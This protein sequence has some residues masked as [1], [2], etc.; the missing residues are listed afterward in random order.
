MKVLA[1]YSTEEILGGG[2]ISFTLSLELV[3]KSGCDVLAALPGTGPLIDYLQKRG[4]PL[5][6]LPQPP[7]RENLNARYLFFPHPDWL[8]LCKGFRP[9]LIHC[10]AVRSALYAQ[11]VGNTLHIPAILHARKSERLRW[12]DPFLVLRL[13]AIICTSEIV[14]RRFPICLGPNKLK[15]VYN[16]VDFAQFERPTSQSR[17]LRE[18]WLNGRFG[19]LVGVIGRLSPIKGQHRIVEAAPEIL[20]SV[21]R[22]RFVL[23]GSED[24]SFPGHAQQLHNDIRRRGLEDH[25]VFAGYQTEIA[26]FYHALDVVAFPTSSEGFG[27]VVIEA[28]AARKAVVMSDIAVLREIVSTELEDLTVPLGDVLLLAKRIVLLLRDKAL[29]AEVGERLYHHVQNHFGLDAHRKQLLSTYKELTSPSP[30]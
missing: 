22:T 2:E 17:E 10:N 23:I 28:G 8:Q 15:V 3:A 26:S 29:R 5:V 20:R 13:T 30:A 6:R 4:I 1:V 25:F 21:P 19:Q 9:D 24:P 16:P 18:K 7:M 14:R 27:R 11:A 12:I